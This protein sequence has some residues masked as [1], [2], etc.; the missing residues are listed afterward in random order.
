MVGA[1]GMRV[2]RVYGSDEILFYYYRNFAYRNSKM[3]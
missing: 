2:L 1:E 3:L